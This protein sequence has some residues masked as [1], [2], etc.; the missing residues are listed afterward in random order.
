MSKPRADNL[1]DLIYEDTLGTDRVSSTENH[2]ELLE[3]LDNLTRTVERGLIKLGLTNGEARLYV[4]LARTGAKK[5]S[6]VTK[7]TGLARSETYTI[8]NSLRKKGL[9]SCSLR[10]PVDFVAVPFEDALNILIGIE[11]ERLIALER[12]NATLLDAWSLIAS[13]SFK[14]EVREEK[15][16]ILEGNNSIYK[17]IRD[18]ISSAE[19]EVLIC[20]NERHLTRLYHNHIIDHCSMLTTRGVD[21]KVLTNENPSLEL[22]KAVENYDLGVVLDQD[23]KMNFIVVDKS[24]VIFIKDNSLMN[25]QSAIWTD[26]DPLVQSMVRLFF[27]LLKRT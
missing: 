22:L 9:V 16:Q 25:V 5:A 2:A 18:I 1:E 27:E 26:C 10:Y 13:S 23:D 15:F 8:L 12:Q 11:K 20:A 21:V 4:F 19:E 24:Q 3:N 17:R 7:L 6:E 14:R